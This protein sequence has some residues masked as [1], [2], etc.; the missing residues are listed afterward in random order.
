MRLYIS[1]I[2]SV[3]LRKM[4]V[5]EEKKYVR[6]DLITLG[7]SRL[8]TSARAAKSVKWSH[9]QTVLLRLDFRRL[10]WQPA[11]DQL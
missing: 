9:S 1:A 11:V 5:V 2:K 6:A 4:Q 8:L 3:A 10:T 7:S